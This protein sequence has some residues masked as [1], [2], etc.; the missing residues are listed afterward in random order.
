MTDGQARKIFI[1]YRVREH[2]ELLPPILEILR[3]DGFEVY[4][5]GEFLPEANLD[6]ASTEIM[7][8]FTGV[9]TVTTLG[10]LSCDAALVLLGTSTADPAGESL[11][12]WQDWLDHLALAL[13]D[14]AIRGGGG[15]PLMTGVGDAAVVWYLMAY[16]Y[17]IRKRLDET[18]QDWEVRMC[19]FLGVQLVPFVADAEHVEDQVRDLLP[20]LR[21]VPKGR[22]K[23]VPKPGFAVAMAT[24]RA[25]LN[26]IDKVHTGVDAVR[27]TAKQSAA[28][29]AESQLAAVR[30]VQKL[31]GMR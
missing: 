20:L 1:S 17:D 22:M 13:Q 19:D 12:R 6:P 18:W 24:G 27:R 15:A 26:G 3:Q 29:M 10:L 5:D 25:V 31:F 2:R 7:P 11:T 14:L 16:D 23:P 4:F 8:K 30:A 9:P 21:R 28:L